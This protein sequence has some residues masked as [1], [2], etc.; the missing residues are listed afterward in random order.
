MIRKYFYQFKKKFV[1]YNL[2]SFLFLKF[3]AKFQWFGP[4]P[5]IN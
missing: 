2:I 4:R 3:A 5:I 1:N